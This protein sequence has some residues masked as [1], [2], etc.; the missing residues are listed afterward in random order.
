ML[1]DE[2]IL[3]KLNSF[4]EDEMIEKVILPLYRKR[5]RGSS[6]TSNSAGR[7]SVRMVESTSS[8]TRSQ[9][10]RRTSVTRVFR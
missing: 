5:F 3:E 4:T 6:L 7:T 10:I 2:V 9:Q 8:I 1:S